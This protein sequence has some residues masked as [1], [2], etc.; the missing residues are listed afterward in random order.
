[1]SALLHTLLLDPRDEAAARAG[2]ILGAANIPATELTSRA[3]E[4]PPRNIE[5]AIADVGD[6][7]RRAAS[8]LAP[9]HRRCRVTR[10]FEYAASEGACRYRLWRPAAWLETCVNGLTPGRALDLAC[11]S[12]RESAYL[13]ALGW[14][15]LGVDVLPDALDQARALASRYV[16]AGRVRL[17]RRDLEAEPL[18]FDERFDLMIGFRYLHRALFPLLPNWLTPTGRVI[19]ETFTT[20][21]RERHGKPSRDAYL[22]QPGELRTLLSTWQ[23]ERYEEGWINDAHT[24]RVMARRVVA[25]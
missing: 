8:T 12:G 21:H 10:D 9:M 22:L 15:V 14:D 3:F 5:I 19:Y 24:A 17:E 25:S 16:P 6:D 7:A 11:G 4:L 23:I 2:P 20:L 13:A 1:M 18:A